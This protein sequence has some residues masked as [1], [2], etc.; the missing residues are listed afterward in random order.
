M[1]FLSLISGFIPQSGAYYS[2][3]WDTLNVFSTQNPKERGR[4]QTPSTTVALSS[5][6]GS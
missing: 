3:M 6:R 1:L 5:N 2:F 4:L